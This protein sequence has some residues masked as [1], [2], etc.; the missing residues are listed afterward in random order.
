MDI[1]GL[2]EGSELTFP[3]VMMDCFG[4]WGIN[5]FNEYEDPFFAEGEF[6]FVIVIIDEY[7][8]SFSILL[9]KSVSGEIFWNK[10]WIFD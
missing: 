3:Y 9:F 4:K 7:H 10:P 6:E 5:S 8:Q 1:Q 2:L